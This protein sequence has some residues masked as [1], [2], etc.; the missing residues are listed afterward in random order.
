MFRGQTLIHQQLYRLLW[1]LAISSLIALLAACNDTESEPRRI[2]ATPD[3]AHT[4]DPTSAPDAAPS[5]TPVPVTPSPTPDLLATAAVNA[6]PDAIGPLDY[7]PGINPLTGQPVAE[8]GALDRPPL[9]VKISNAPD[10][11]RPQAGIGQADIVFEHY[12]EGSLTRFSALFWSQTPPRVGSVRSARLIDLQLPQMYGALFAYSG[13]NATIQQRITESTFAPRAY[14]GV[15]VGEP[16]YYRDPGIEM[17]HNLFI[18][19]GDVWA[20]AAQDGL[21]APP[22]LPGMVFRNTPPESGT[23][24]KRVTVDYGPDLVEWAY[25]DASGTYQRTVNGDPH[26]DAN[27]DAQISAANVIVL[28]APHPDDPDIVAGEWAGEVYYHFAIPLMA[29]GPAVICRDGQRVQGVW[30]RVIHAD[31]SGVLTFWQD[32]DSGTPVALKPGNT[33]IEVVPSDFGPAWVD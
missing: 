2:T 25:D 19:P 21:D 4:A 14:E 26:R 3:P 18:V 30:K 16:L 12:V 5:V 24:A 7:P 15:S 22:A 27:T 17:P 11:V 23:A 20:R 28:Y 10:V 13:A 8:P 1:I 9:L 31:G 32:D 6:P 33:W 29:G